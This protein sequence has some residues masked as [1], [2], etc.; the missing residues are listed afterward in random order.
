MNILFI[1]LI[2]LMLGANRMR[3]S[4]Y[5]GMNTS[6]PSMTFTA[7]QASAFRS[8]KPCSSRKAFSS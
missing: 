8:A 2:S 1:S 7:T 3:S 6:C 4:T 5:N